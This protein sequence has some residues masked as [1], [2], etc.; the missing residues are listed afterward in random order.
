MW[1]KESVLIKWD[2]NFAYAIGLFT[3]DGSLSIDG[4]HLD[5]TSKDK[6]QIK[7]FMKCLNLKNKIGRKSRDSEKIKKYFCVQFGDVRFY[8]FL[9]SIGLNPRKSLTLKYVKIPNRFFAD[10]LRGLLD[11]DGNI[12]SFKHPES[13][14][15]QLRVR[16]SSGTRE[17][18][19][20]LRR[21][22]NKNLNLENRGSIQCYVK[23]KC[24]SYG[25]ED[26]IKILKY[27]YYSDEI[28]CLARKWVQAKVFLP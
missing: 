7:N 1:P 21:V 24:L 25:K 18:L 6:E 8:R 22:T 9:Q 23:N 28:I 5:F 13:Q 20:W 12:N 19:H 15:L 14:Y 26:S 11:G 27:I 4:R 17:F 10:F 16:F 2:E 3:A